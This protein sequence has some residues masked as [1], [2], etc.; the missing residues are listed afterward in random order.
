M[1]H[2]FEA[3]LII[4]HLAKDVTVT[5]GNEVVELVDAA[6][7]GERENSLFR[8]QIVELEFSKL[9]VKPRAAKQV[10]EPGHHRLKVEGGSVVRR[11]ENVEREVL[12]QSP[13]GVKV[14]A[15]K[16]EAGRGNACDRVICAGKSTT[17][18]GIHENLAGAHAVPDRCDT[19]GHRPVAGILPD[20]SIAII[21]QLVAVVFELLAKVVEHG[22]R[23]MASRTAQAIFAR[24]GGQSFRRLAATEDDGENNQSQGKQRGRKAKS[25]AQMGTRRNVHD[26]TPRQDQDQICVLNNTNTTKAD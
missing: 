16:I 13:A 25:L 20:R 3:E 21:H 5:L 24:E 15:A 6:I 8:K 17:R 10:I 2:H 14:E 23:L 9:H 1:A 11:R 22:P 4:A 7:S 12:L 19:E 18:V 26:R